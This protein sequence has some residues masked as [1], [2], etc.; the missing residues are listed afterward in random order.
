MAIR[1]GL[2]SQLGWAAE[3]TYGTGV[4]PDHFAQHVGFDVKLKQ[5]DIKSAAIRAGQ[6]VLRSDQR[7]QNKIGAEGSVEFEARTKGLG[8]WHKM[9]WGASVITTPGGG[10]LTR[11]HSYSI[12]DPYGLFMTVQG[13]VPDV[14]GTV[15]P[16]TWLGTK[17]TSWKLSQ[18]LDEILMLECG[19][20]VQDEVTATALATATYP[21][22]DELFEYGQCA[23]TVNASPFHA[24]SFEFELARNLATERRFLRGSRLKKEPVQNALAELGGSLKGEFEDLT[25]LGLFTA[26]APV[27]I[28]ATWTGSLIEGALNHKLTL[29]LPSCVI[30]EA[31]PELDGTEIAEQPVG[32]YVV[33][34]DATLVW[35]TVETAD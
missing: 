20:D 28:T 24:A 31:D 4:T 2:A 10:T 35:D 7:V 32:Y 3:T 25:V 27:A 9:A 1:S 15:R 12:A 8:L 18:E 19:V 16:F 6:Q 11:R 17:V 33:N 5:D 26:G 13:G 23:I 21:A 30:L 34:E 22:S 29:T 14:G